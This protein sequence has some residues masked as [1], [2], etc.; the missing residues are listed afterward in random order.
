MFLLKVGNC[1]SYGYIIEPNLV[2]LRHSFMVGNRN[3][4]LGSQPEWN[5]GWESSSARA[6][7]S[8]PNASILSSNCAWIG[9]LISIKLVNNL[10]PFLQVIVLDYTLCIIKNISKWVYWL[11]NLLFRL[12]LGSRRVVV[13]A[14]FMHG[15]EMAPILEKVFS[16]QNNHSKLKP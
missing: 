3:L 7:Y 5:G 10:Y 16:H 9:P 4:S 15:H 8:W 14:N 12:L 2:P 11:T 6:V 13:N 1:F